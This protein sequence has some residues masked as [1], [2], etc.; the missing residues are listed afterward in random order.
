MIEIFNV[1]VTILG[2]LMSLGHFPQAYKIFKNRS[3]KDVSLITYSIFTIGSY[4]WLV[5]GILIKEI[6]VIISFSIAV[7]GTTLV[8]ILALK[9]KKK[10]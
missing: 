2:I 9:Y 10:N 6:P 3:S 4:I 8:L 5:Y 1:I 7:I